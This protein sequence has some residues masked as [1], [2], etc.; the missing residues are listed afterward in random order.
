M[1]ANSNFL[2]R[3]VWKL[4]FRDVGTTWS[5]TLLWGVRALLS[6][7]DT[8]ANV[9]E[10]NTADEWTVFAGNTPTW[11]ITAEVLK[12][13]DRDLLRSLFGG[14]ATTTAWTAV[15]VA[16]THEDSVL[17]A[18]GTWAVWEVVT[19]KKWNWNKT[20]VTGVTI[21]N[22]TTAVPTA[23]YRVYV[24]DWVTKAINI[25]TS[26][27]T[28]TW[29]W[30][31]A[32]YTYTPNAKET[33]AL[34]LKFQEN[35]DFEVRIIWT[36]DNNKERTVTLSSAR[37]T[38]AVGLSFDD[39]AEAGDIQGAQMTFTWNRNSKFTIDNEILTSS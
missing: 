19:F 6:T 25:H 34:D 4:Y 31:R 10:V 23:Q 28:L 16:T 24:E 1:T 26:A 20:I 39:V 38:S 7:Y 3:Y 15:N 12:I 2:Q 11:T 17:K 32:V 29:T 30:L 8:S 22:N 37:I 35:K 18:S 36:D 27:I 13:F 9:V 14:T 5:F 21:N 33:L